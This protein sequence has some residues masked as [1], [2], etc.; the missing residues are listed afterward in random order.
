MYILFKVNDIVMKVA[1]SILKIL[2]WERMC[3]VLKHFCVMGQVT[4]AYH[5]QKK[6]F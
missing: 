2:F 1:N 3:K 5:P 4:K 6:G